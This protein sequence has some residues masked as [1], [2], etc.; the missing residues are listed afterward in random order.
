MSSLDDQQV[1]YARRQFLAVPLAGTLVWLFIAIAAIFLPLQ[2]MPWVLFAGTGSIFY[3]GI[4]LSNLLGEPIFDKQ[5]EKNCFDQLFLMVLCMALLVYA[6]AIPFF[7]V[8]PDSLPLSIGI[9]TGLMWLPFSWS[10][11]HWLGIFHALTRTLGV[12]LVWYLFPQQ[13]YLAVAIVIMAVYLVTLWLLRRRW[14]L[15]PK[16]AA[17]TP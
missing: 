1:I 5:R 9:L 17:H 16:Q 4:F 6:I 11:K 10:I 7:L 3:I 14:L 2:V 12:L 15:L 13:R 8:Q